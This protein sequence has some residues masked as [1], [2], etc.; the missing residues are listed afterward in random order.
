MILNNR[1]ILSDNWRAILVREVHNRKTADASDHAEWL[2][3][4]AVKNIE[5][6]FLRLAA[7][8]VDGRE[9][10]WI[11]T[12]N[13]AVSPPS[14]LVLLFMFDRCDVSILQNT[15]NLL[16]HSNAASEVAD[17]GLA[18]DRHVV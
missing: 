9:C 2:H 13:H 12:F 6:E 8:K 3:V 16:H 14:R 17:I 10:I 7:H 4:L 5:Q 1:H 11:E 15:S 18:A